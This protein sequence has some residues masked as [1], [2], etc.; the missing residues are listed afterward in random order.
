M[1]APMASIACSRQQA[2][3]G[4][5]GAVGDGG[6]CSCEMDRSRANRR[7]AAQGGGAAPHPQLSCAAPQLPQLP[8][9]SAV[10]RSAEQLTVPQPRSSTVCPSNSS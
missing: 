5:G 8:R 3:G 4:R 6:T 7:L 1:A 10:Q 9:R 2:A